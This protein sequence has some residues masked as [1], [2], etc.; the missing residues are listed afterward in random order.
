MNNKFDLIVIGGGHAGVEAA[1]AGR[2]MKLDV[3]LI[4]LDREKIGRMSCNPA[5]GG[6]GKTH[7]AR[8]IDALGGVIAEATDLSGIQFKTLNRKKGPAVQALRA[9]TDKNLYEKTIQSFIN[10]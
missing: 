8:E 5:V 2:R 9:Q 1:V 7:L 3:A 10:K 6:I 4:T